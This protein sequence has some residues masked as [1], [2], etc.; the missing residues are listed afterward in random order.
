MVEDTSAVPT[1][2]ATRM[3]SAVVREVEV[4]PGRVS[5][6]IGYVAISLW[7]TA[8]VLEGDIPLLNLGI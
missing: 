2:D 4:Q 3:M 6:S 7:A 5:L 1:I 8:E